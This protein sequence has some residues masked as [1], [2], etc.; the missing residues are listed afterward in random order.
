MTEEEYEKAID[1]FLKTRGGSYSRPS[2]WLEHG[3]VFS[4]DT[5]PV[6]V[7]FASRLTPKGRRSFVEDLQSKY[8]KD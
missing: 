4:C 8:A 5:I 1:D 3:L 6:T 2:G 7:P